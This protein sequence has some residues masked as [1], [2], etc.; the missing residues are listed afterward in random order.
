MKII[1]LQSNA[2]SC[3]HANTRLLSPEKEVGGEAE[4]R[5]KK[6]NRRE[7]ASRKMRVSD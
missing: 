6:R 3:Q 4:K 7:A 5:E 1:F 2:I